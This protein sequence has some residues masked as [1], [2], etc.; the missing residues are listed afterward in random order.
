MK[1]TKKQKTIEACKELIYK[2]KHPHGHAFFNQTVCPLCIIHHNVLTASCSGC[3]LAVKY[4]FY[5]CLLFKSSQD[6]KETYLDILS[7]NELHGKAEFPLEEQVPK[8]FVA[9]AKF[10]EKIIPILET[11]PKSKFTISGW[12]YFEE[13]KSDW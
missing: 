1:K 4:I 12:T 5:G 7:R 11:L 8:E 13:I 9:R 2:Y 3:P 10:F 6:A